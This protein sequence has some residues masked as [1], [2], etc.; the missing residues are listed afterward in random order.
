[1]RKT[2]LTLCLVLA[3]SLTAWADGPFRN[4]RYSALSVLQPTSE[5]IVFLGNSITNMHE[6]AEAFGN[7]NILNRGCSGAVTDEMLANVEQVL[8]GHPAKIFFLMGTNDLGTA[9][10]N[11]AAYVAKN[12]RKMLR[13][14]QKASP[15]TKLYVQSILP[16]VSNNIKSTDQVLAAN[17]SI[18]A[19]CKE[20][21]GV[22]FIDLYD[23]L[24]GIPTYQ[25]S[26]DGIHL[27]AAAY[28]IW[29]KAIEEYVGS[30][31]VYPDNASDNYGGLGGVH[32]MRNSYF[33][34]SP[35]RADD[36]LIIGDAT[37]NGGEW[38]ELLHSGAVKKRASG[39]GG[40][41]TPIGTVQSMLPSIFQG[42]ADNVAPKQIFVEL[43]WNEAN[44]NTDPATA[45]ETYK[46]FINKVRTYAPNTP[47]C[48]LAVYPTT[49]ATKN[50]N[51]VVP[52]NAKLDSLAKTM[53][54]VTYA[55]EAYTSLVDASTGAASTTLFNSYYLYG[56]G[57]A[58][59]SQVIAKYAI[60][61]SNL[62]G[63][64]DA[65][66]E[67]HIATWTA[68]QALTSA[69]YNAE[70]VGIG[71]GTGQY[72]A[73]N[74]ATLLS[75]IDDSYKLL[76]DNASD[77]DITARSTALASSV[78]AI[79]PNINMPQA[80]TT[81]AEVWYQ[82]T[83]P[84]RGNRYLTSQGSGSALVGA[85]TG[86][87]ASSMWKFVS[88]GDG[89]FDI[90]NRKDASYISPVATYNAAVSTAATQ[91]SKGW[92]LSYAN[93]PG[94]YIISCGTVELNQTQSHQNY[95]IYNWS[96]GQSG[97]DRDDKGC[98]FAIAIAPDP[99][100]EPENDFTRASFTIDSSTGSLNRGTNTFNSK[101]T[102]TSTNPGLVLSTTNGANNMWYNG[103]TNIVA[104]SGSAKACTYQLA[105]DAG[106]V[107]TDYGFTFVNTT[108]GASITLTAGSESYTLSD[109]EQTLTVS[110]IN[111]QTTTFSLSGDNKGV[112]LRDFYVVIAKVGHEN[113]PLTGVT[114]AEALQVE[115]AALLH[116]L[117][118]RRINAPRK[119]QVYIKAGKK[120]IGK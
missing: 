41:G 26:K 48:F 38:H 112:E 101:W 21:D 37:M 31:C 13:H 69:L 77:A 23:K 90:V 10:T 87:T 113:D 42:R 109:N 27:T 20:F 118:G 9:G 71:A 67:A 74:A 7:P 11:T 76:A 24:P 2:L 120:F 61:G 55:P 114:S 79:L 53:E 62:V 34:M 65:E 115:G 45:I 17:D 51:Y 94:V 14:C 54:N 92:T 78:S 8:V 63:T 49:D 43:G 107:I 12:V 80:S 68:R 32:A 39:W 64:T 108:T 35:V 89:T 47:I 93:T 97:T 83:T 33:A 91:P 96:S 18:E 100:E 19:I 95:A 66:A 3:A 111:A 50:A 106:Y 75:A 116:D 103:G 73:E 29:C 44:N 110:G 98:Q 82:L 56:R 84:N 85:E 70:S 59:L 88:R 72:T 86:T 52:F 1:M 46:T 6:W 4:H 105:T 30:K 16:C 104:Y 60:E 5:S 102:A 40:A 117:S 81:G 15:T 36:V 57:F 25:Y 119:G 99:E 58:R 28:R 22:T